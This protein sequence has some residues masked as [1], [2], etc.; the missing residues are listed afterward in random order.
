MNSTTVIHAQINGPVT[1]SGG[2][3]QLGTILKKGTKAYV[4][5]NSNRK[6]L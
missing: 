1:P 3:D 4:T 6:I 5:G 2:F